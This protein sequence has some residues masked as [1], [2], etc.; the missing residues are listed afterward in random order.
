[1]KPSKRGKHPISRSISRSTSVSSACRDKLT[2]NDFSPRTTRLAN[3]GKSSARERVA[4]TDAFPKDKDEFVWESIQH[5][6]RDN[7]LLQEAL[8]LAQENIDDKELLIE[9]V[10][11]L[12]YTNYNYDSDLII[13]RLVM[14]LLGF[15]VI[16][17]SRPRIALLATMGFQARCLELKLKTLFVGF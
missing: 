10:R 16:L 8:Q 1:M 12:L 15:V 13:S 17:N 14:R 5:G 4:F 3:A 6:A 7:N 11:V 2:K 9:Y